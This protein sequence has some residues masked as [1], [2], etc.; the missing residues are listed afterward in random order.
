MLTACWKG[1][2]K[3]YTIASKEGAMKKIFL[4]ILAVVVTLSLVGGA[5]AGGPKAPQSLCLNVPN[6][7]MLFNIV[8]KPGGSM[9]ISGNQ[10][11]KFY[12][13]QGNTSDGPIS[14][15]ITGTGY[16]NGDIFHFNC[17]AVLYANPETISIS[18]DAYFNVTNGTGD[19]YLLRFSTGGILPLNVQLQAVPCSSVTI[20]N[21]EPTSELS[22]PA[23]FTPVFLE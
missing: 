7:T 2:K 15:P 18:G 17:T 20:P 13:I 5:A 11:V 8:T 22:D 4:T 6:R 1:S 12:D 3:P 19:M 23:D 16:M 21:S 9:K 14:A 10:T